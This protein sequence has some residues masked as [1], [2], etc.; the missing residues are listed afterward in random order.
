MRAC[1]CSLVCVFVALLSATSVRA[2]DV[3]ARGERPDHWAYQPMRK[4]AL[5]A[6]RDESW[7]QSP[8]DD[9]VLVGLEAAEIAPPPP[10]WPNTTWCLGFAES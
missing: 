4:S 8:I 10:R 9:F 7:P 3:A 2:A 6:V 1:G 5:P